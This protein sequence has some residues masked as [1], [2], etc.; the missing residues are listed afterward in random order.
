MKRKNEGSSVKERLS[1][2]QKPTAG[3]LVKAGTNRLGKDTLELMIERRHEKERVEHDKFTAT[4]D[5]WKKTLFAYSEFKEVN[6]PEAMW[7]IKDHMTVL[8]ELRVDK[9]EKIP[10]K[11]QD[12]VELHNEWKSRTPPDVKDV[13]LTNNLRLISTDVEEDDDLDANSFDG[14]RDETVAI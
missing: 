3:N 12:L 10:K 14:L 2:H 5:E 9:N 8:R 6:K 7:A 13:G 11:K 4:R 1:K